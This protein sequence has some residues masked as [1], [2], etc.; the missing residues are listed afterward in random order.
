MGNYRGITVSS[1]FRKLFEYSLLSKLNLPQSDHQFGFTSG[2][3][4]VMAGLLVNETKS[5]AIQNRHPQ[6]PEL[7]Y[8]KN[9]INSP[10]VEYLCPPNRRWGTYC[11]W[12]GSRRRRRR[13]QRRRRRPRRRP[14]P[15]SFF[16]TRYLL[17]QWMDFDQTC[18]DTWLG[19]GKELIRFW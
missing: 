19:G 15:R 2:L 4:P 17:N 6:I 5:E 11:F 10:S 12:C 14:R 18:I 9:W 8:I 13:R 16:L 1:T 7:K 3:S